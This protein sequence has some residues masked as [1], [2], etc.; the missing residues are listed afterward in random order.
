M[1]EEQKSRQQQKKPE[2]QEEKNEKQGEKHEKSWDEKWR[3]DQLSAVIWAAVFIWAGIIFLL[4]NL[5]TLDFLIK[6]EGEEFWFRMEGAWSI[7]LVGAGVIFLVEVAIRL[8]MPVYRK[9]VIGTVI[10]A[11]ILIGIGL[12]SLV[13]WGIIWA[14]VLIIIGGSILFRGLRGSSGE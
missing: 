5:G 3:R 13:N 8:L 9:P 2:K 4:S 1:S 6:P 12:G 7:V 14:V 10:F 11:M